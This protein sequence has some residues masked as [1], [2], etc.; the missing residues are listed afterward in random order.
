MLLIVAAIVTCTELDQHYYLAYLTFWTWFNQI[1]FCHL[2][3][4][5]SVLSFQRMYLTNRASLF[6]VFLFDKTVTHN[7]A[8][9]VS[10][11]KSSYL[12]SYQC[13]CQTISSFLSL[14]FSLSLTLS[15]FFSFFCCHILDCLFSSLLYLLK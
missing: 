6:L 3:K 7:Q 2:C 13:E 9:V 10:T 14:P 15:L 8:L 12:C 4:I 5:N 1:I 11:I